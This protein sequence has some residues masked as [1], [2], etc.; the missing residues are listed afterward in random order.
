MSCCTRR[1]FLA[2]AAAALAAPA[3]PRVAR[4]AAP[5]KLGTAVLGDYALAGPFI[6]A[7]E[8]GLFKHEGLAVEYI[9]FRGGPDLVKAVIAGEILIGTA[10]STD[11]LV[12]REAGMPLKMTATHT[13]GNHF[14]LNV[15][16]EIQ[17][18][19]DLKGRAIGVTRVGATTWV[20]ARML[21][22]KEGWDA[23]RDVKIVGLGGLDA[24]LAALARKEIHAFVWGDGGAVTQYQGKSKVLLRLDAVTPKWISQIQYASEDGIRKHP[25]AIRQAMRALFA[26]LAW[27]KAHPA[28]AAEVTSKRLGWPL[29]AV[30]GAHRISSPLFS[31]DGSI[32]V[33]ALAAM[34]DTLL[35]YGVIKKRLPLEEHVAREFT[36]VRT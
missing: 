15:A 9:P 12:F 5:V 32:N 25:E 27:M 19:S 30:L 34:Q 18:L 14:T 23:D 24:Q 20:F 11:I 3:V 28:E 7:L 36:P 8:R 33:E 6:V 21:A 16:P 31:L 17:R 2:S 35:E 13:E 10:G 29:E 26:A 4:A 22:R 1:V